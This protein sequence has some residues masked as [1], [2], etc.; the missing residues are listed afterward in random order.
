MAQKDKCD[1]EY[2]FEVLFSKKKKKKYYLLKLMQKTSFRDTIF[3]IPM[4]L[5]GWIF[6]NIAGFTSVIDSINIWTYH[7]PQRGNAEL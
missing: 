1:S 5:Y 4:I 6:L 2:C 3:S 7:T